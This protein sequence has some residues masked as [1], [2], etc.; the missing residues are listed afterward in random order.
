MAI[1]LSLALHESRG[2]P[3]G[4]IVNRPLI[5]RS[6]QSDGCF[7]DER[8]AYLV[9]AI[10]DFCPSFEASGSHDGPHFID[11]RD[12]PLKPQISLS[13][14]CA[15][16]RVLFAADIDA[17]HFPANARCFGAVGSASTSNRRDWSPQRFWTAADTES[18]YRRARY[19]RGHTGLIPANLHYVRHFSV[20]FSSE[21][22]NSLGV[23]AKTMLPSHQTAAGLVGSARSALISRLAY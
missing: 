18:T 4:D 22:P 8:A 23:L 21:P 13:Y 12:D 10:R 16:L 7:G 2:S 6:D 14:A 9:Q 17:N 5:G 3:L 20:C 19:S 15:G 11:R 1:R